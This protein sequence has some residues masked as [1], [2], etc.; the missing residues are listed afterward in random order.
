MTYLATSC[1]EARGQPRKGCEE[2]Y[3][4][5]RGFVKFGNVWHDADGI[6]TVVGVIGALGGRRHNR[7]LARTGME[8]WIQQ[9]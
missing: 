2:H 5:G 9:R 1:I 7:S 4:L 6:I 3:S 8:R